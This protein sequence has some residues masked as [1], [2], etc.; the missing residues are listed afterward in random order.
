MQLELEASQMKESDGGGL[1]LAA[2]LSVSETEQLRLGYGNTLRE[3]LQ[4][5]DTWVSTA[6]QMIGE[7]G[8]LA[9]FLEHIQALVFT[10]SG[11]SEYAGECVRLVLQ[12]EVGV[13]TQTIAG[14]VLLTNGGTAVAPGRPAVVV[15]LARSGDSPESV[16]AVSLL[17]ETEPEI[18][19]LVITCNRDGALSTT[20]TNEPRVKVIVLDERTNDRSLVM[21]S[22]FTNMVLAARSLGLLG[23]PDEYRRLA[24]EASAAARKILSNEVDAIADVASKDFD[25]VL[26]LA[27]GPRVGAAREAALK[28]MEMTAGKVLPLCE[29]YLGLRHGPMSA[30][31]PDSLI[32]CFLSS[33]SPSREYE[34]DLIRELQRKQLGACKV[35]FGANIPAD[36]TQP[37]DL[38]L[39]CEALE[40]IGDDTAPILD[41]IVGQLLAFFRC[42]HEGVTPDSPSRAGVI[43]RVVEEFALHVWNR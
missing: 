10:G 15:S 21:T 3:I 29:T 41:I 33:G 7:S 43:N 13:V 4:Q 30:I 12:N 22:S 25:R 24:R 6:D 35:I 17:L 1:R 32:V 28:M 23:Q 31:H 27:S 36:L 42:M 34:C 40:S 37:G 9:Q 16:A 2:L 19:H 11:S 18:K 14:G 26:F 20:Y 38:A 8:A 39:E 5:P